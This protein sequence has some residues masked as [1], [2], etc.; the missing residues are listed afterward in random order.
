MHGP[1]A[2]RR[3][4]LNL[5]FSKGVRKTQLH[6]FSGPKWLSNIQLAFF[7]R[8]KDE[9]EK[10]EEE[11]ATASGP[12]N[13]ERKKTRFTK[14]KKSFFPRQQQEATLPANIIIFF[15]TT[16][17]I[18]CSC[19]AEAA[20]EKSRSPLRTHKSRSSAQA[21]ATSYSS[22]SVVGKKVTPRRR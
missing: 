16:Y 2:G 10:A 22:A 17:T 14:K 11:K 15:P 21:I 7:L 4:T 20:H 19:E 3:R 5:Q 8:A 18:Y 13:G 6:E 12:R 9:R 1:T